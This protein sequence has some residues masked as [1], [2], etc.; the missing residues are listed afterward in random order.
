MTKERIKSFILILLII[1]SI[2]LTAQMWFNSGFWTSEEFWD[3]LREIPIVGSIVNW[4]YEE[5]EEVYTGKQLYDET[6]KP[7]RVVV[8][9]GNAREVYNKKTSS[10]DEV[11]GYIDSIVGEMKSTEVVVDQ[12]TYEEWKNLFKTKSLFVDYGYETDYKNLNRMYGMSSSSGKFSQ[13]TDFTGFIIVPNELTGKCMLC[14]LNERDN[15]VIRHT[16]S[17]NTDKLKS[18]IEQSTYQ[19]QLNNTF[20]FEINLDTLT[21]AE[22]DVERKVAFSPLT[23]LSIPTGSESNVIVQNNGAFKSYDE[24]EAFSEDA[25]TVFG[26]TASSLR[27]NVKSDGT[28]TFVE[29]NATI[30]FYY[31]GTVEYNAVSKEKG[32]RV[33]NGAK[34]SYQAVHDVLNVVSMLWEKSESGNKN[35][36]Y[37]LVSAMEDNEDGNY[38][39]RLDNMVSGITVNYAGVTGN[40]VMAQVDDGYITRLVMHIS[41]ISETGSKN[42]S[43]PVLMAIDSVYEGRGKDIMII[44]DVYRCYDFD[45]NGKGIAKWVFKLK[46]EGEVLVVDTSDIKG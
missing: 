7:R 39:I 16:F 28:I 32:L 30:T 27:K 25:L 2:N 46:D 45:E 11:M 8:N 26:Y 40:A 5:K 6:M 19:K 31:D 42:E 10:Y 35:L 12:I 43:A 1:N 37:Q 18:F 29:N 36:D 44:D 24:F 4:F 3:S 17:A 20:A 34:T 21:S 15:T 41:D 33:S 9:G 38:T 14:M 22:A 23:L 13:A